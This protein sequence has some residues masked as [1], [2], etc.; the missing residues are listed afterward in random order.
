MAIEVMTIR[1]GGFVRHQSEQV[2]LIQQHI[3]PKI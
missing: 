3:G 2:A 1:A